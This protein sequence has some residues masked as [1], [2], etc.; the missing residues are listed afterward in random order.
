VVT[1]GGILAEVVR[2]PLTRQV[3]L[4]AA[5]R[6]ADE[7]GL[8]GLSMRKLAEELGVKPAALY[9]HVSGK[10]AVLDGM[11]ETIMSKMG[12][13]SERAESWEDKVRER[14]LKS[15][16]IAHQHPNVYRL[17]A[18]RFT[19]HIP[20]VL[21]LVEDLLGTLREAGL[22]VPSALHAYRTLVNYTIGYALAEI[23]GFSLEAEDPD[24]PPPFRSRR[25]IP[26]DFP[27]VIELAPY[28]KNVDHDEE[29][30]FGLDCMI[31]G[32]KAQF[33]L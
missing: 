6:I 22:D 5:V 1:L 26:E 10:D 33:E 20:E 28:L 4:D 32:L 15:R 16:E 17:F 24:L 30:M 7:R 13:L 3:V 2:K 23:R 14:L 21:G 18:A 25:P 8:Q 11:I 9:N 31:A 12:S 29:F 27:R 19:T